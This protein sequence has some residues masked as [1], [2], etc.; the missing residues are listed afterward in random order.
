MNGKKLLYAVVALVIAVLAII[1]GEQL[2]KKSPSG[3]SLSFFPN[4]TEKNISAV[5]ITDAQ[6]AVKVRKKG[7]IWVIGSAP[8][9]QST[10]SA[11]IGSDTTAETAVAE[12]SKEYGADSASIATLLEKLTSMKKGEL[13]S[14][15]PS[16][17]SI[18]EVDSANGILVEVW[19]ETGKSKG[20]FKVGKNGPDWSSNYVRM[21]GSNQVYMV[22]GSIRHS[23]FTDHK[24]W[25]DKSIVKFDKSTVTRIALNSKKSPGLALAKADTGVSWDIVEPIKNPAKTDQ[26][27]ELLNTLSRF[28]AA[29]FE[30]SQ[31]SDT[32]MGFSSP[33]L[34]I[35]VTFA[36]G[37]SKNILIGS[38][39][40]DN[41]YR[42]RADGKETVF[43]INESEVNR[44][45]KDSA[46]LKA[47]E[48]KEEPSK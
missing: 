17:Q 3:K 14:E 9:A 29:D 40:G 6:G 27:E 4:M 28:N 47:D 11:G 41:K 35:A 16:K 26:V 21:V 33:E 31:E 39:R 19:D 45:N 44:L 7:D 5:T 36:N 34:A 43:L 15:N 24:R 32:A 20:S 1:L 25:R 13:V 37:S 12:I 48:P 10:T 38:K 22:P 30:E 8:S 23:F 18:F 42:V 46:T 2:N